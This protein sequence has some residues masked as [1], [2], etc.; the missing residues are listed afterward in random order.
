MLVCIKC[1]DSSFHQ[2]SL[3]TRYNCLAMLQNP[4]AH[5]YPDSWSSYNIPK[6]YSL[7][8]CT[9]HR[10]LHLLLC[11][12]YAVLIKMNI[13]VKLLLFYFVKHCALV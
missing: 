7:N 2:L 1:S 5:E 3:N 11:S 9:M 4:C 6:E 8:Q 13:F 10:V 12:T